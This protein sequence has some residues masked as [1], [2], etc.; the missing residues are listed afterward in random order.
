MVLK[1][2]KNM[3]ASHQKKNIMIVEIIEKS[4]DKIIGIKTS[5]VYSQIARMGREQNKFAERKNLIAALEHAFANKSERR[6][7]ITREPEFVP[8]KASLIEQCFGSHLKRLPEDSWIE[9]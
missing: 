6:K 5:I 1:I 3:D 7:I 9:I 4:P 8:M 2:N